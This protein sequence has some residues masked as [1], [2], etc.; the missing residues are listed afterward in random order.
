MDFLQFCRD[1]G[2]PLA[3][4]GHK[5]HRAGWINVP[6][7][8]C[9]G[10]AGFHLGYEVASKGSGFVCFRCGGHG[11][12]STIARLARITPKKAADLIE[13]YGGRPYTTSVKAKRE[14]QTGK[15]IKLPMGTGPLNDA[16]MDYLEARGFDP[17]RLEKEF[18]L[19]ATGPVGKHRL[20]IVI[21]VQYQG[22]NVTYTC[23]SYAGSDTRYIACDG[24]DELIPAKDIL[25]NIDSVP[26]RKSIAVTEGCPNV[27]RL[28]AG[29][30]ATFGTKVTPSQLKFL[31]QFR[32]VV[33]LRDIDDAGL[34][35]WRELHAR[36]SAFGV[37]VDMPNLGLPEGSDVAEMDEREAK[38]LMRQLL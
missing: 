30:V 12:V 34:N 17:E 11:G 33:L 35:A 8:F 27:W 37:D 38:Y 1:Y 5:H 25:Y 9:T 24:A 21:P 3:P 19:M 14:W 23:R 15:N 18:D 20:R 26:S 16:A 6:C 10:N 29:A 22:F 36:L 2:L 31:V 28:G 4:H 32:R 7:P 13:Q